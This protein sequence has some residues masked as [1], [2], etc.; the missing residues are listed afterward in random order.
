[1]DTNGTVLGPGENSSPALPRNHWLALVANLW[2]QRNHLGTVPE[3]ALTARG[4]DDVS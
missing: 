3:R 4:H 2:A 1:M